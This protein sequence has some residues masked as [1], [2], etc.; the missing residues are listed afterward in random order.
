MI[1]VTQIPKIFGGKR[2]SSSK[3]QDFMIF[4]AFRVSAAIAKRQD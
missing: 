4:M 2:L 3:I 1:I